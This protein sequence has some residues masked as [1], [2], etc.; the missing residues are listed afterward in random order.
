MLS[1]LILYTAIQ[2][3]RFVCFVTNRSH[4]LNSAKSYNLTHCSNIG[5]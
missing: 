2:K 4:I 1:M 3:Y 5:V